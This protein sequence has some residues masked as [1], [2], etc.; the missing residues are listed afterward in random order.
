MMPGRRRGI[1]FLAFVLTAGGCAAGAT[2]R[3]A[4]AAPR[5]P[6]PMMAAASPEPPA[7]GEYE[8]LPFMSR[9]REE[10]QAEAPGVGRL[11]ARTLGALIFI[12]GLIAAAAWGLRRIGGTNR[13]GPSEERP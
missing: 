12:V 10:A 5:A 9:T 2:D 8:D 13:G 6:A 4:A 1:W 7:P 3:Q 11:F